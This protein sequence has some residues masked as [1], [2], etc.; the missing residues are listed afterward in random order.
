MST[1]GSPA[2]WV[3]SEVFGLPRVGEVIPVSVKPGALRVASLAGGRL[4]TDFRYR[5]SSPRSWASP[6]AGSWLSS[7]A[8]W[9]S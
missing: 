3:S 6:R 5:P 9:G 1:W 4:V 7:Y 2:I 8:G